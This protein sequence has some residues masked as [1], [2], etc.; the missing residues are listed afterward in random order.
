VP[1]IKISVVV[2]ASGL[3]LAMVGFAV[4]ITGSV[5]VGMG[6]LSIGW[7]I[8][9]AF[10]ALAVVALV[11][12]AAPAA[13]APPPGWFSDPSGHASQRYWDGTTWTDHTA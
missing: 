1:S 8:A 2:A 11:R 12:R 9:I 13:Q 5:G 4:F 3:L 7:L 6:L 10:G